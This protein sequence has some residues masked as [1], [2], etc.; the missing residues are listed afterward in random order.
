MCV[1][2]IGMERAIAI[3]GLGEQESRVERTAHRSAA[4]LE[5]M[6]GLF[7]TY[8]PRLY[9]YA[10]LSLRDPDLAESLA[11]DCLM[12]AHAARAQ[13]R[14]ECS[15]GTWLT[16]IA[17]NMIRDHVRLRKVQFWKAA[18]SRSVEVSEMAGRLRAP[19][20]SPETSLLAR[21]QVHQVWAAVEGLSENQ[22]S[23]FLLRF[24]EEMELAEIAEALRMNVS[25]VKSH[26]HRALG[27]VRGKMEVAR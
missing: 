20:A 15:V 7:R 10:L 4:E 16:R 5:D 13:F 19:G 21:E 22:R 3:T 12:K 14:G 1:H 17:T 8:R 6:D 2:S 25:T 27:A 26:L 24:V 11:H 23:V 18:S 9:R